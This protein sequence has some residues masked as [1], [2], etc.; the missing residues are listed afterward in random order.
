[1]PSIMSTVRVNEGSNHEGR[2]ANSAEVEVNVENL[3]D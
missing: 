3:T 2:E 1:M